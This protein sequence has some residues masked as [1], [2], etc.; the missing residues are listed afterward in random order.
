MVGV[1]VWILI[2]PDV[3]D[4]ESVSADASNS[5]LLRVAAILLIVVGGLLFVISLI[6]IIGA[7][8]EHRVVLGI[9]MAFLIIIFLGE[10]AGGVL[11]IVFK[12]SLLDNLNEAVSDSLQEYF[13]PGTCELSETG[14]DWEVVQ[15]ELKCCGTDAPDRGYGTL[16]ITERRCLN[17][18][19]WPN[20]LPLSCYQEKEEVCLQ[21]ACTPWPK[22]CVEAI[23]DKVT[24]Y[25]PILIGIGLGVAMIQ[26]IGIIFATCLC[27]NVPAKASGYKRHR[28]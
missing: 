11:A 5:D 13:N 12:D 4:I 15:K 17:S 22:S 28:H 25:A 9:F 24:Y 20:Q 23:E 14:N 18:K 16:N 6:G 3:E 27:V 26:T 8:I 7:V 21:N 10:I 2:A 1:A 19:H